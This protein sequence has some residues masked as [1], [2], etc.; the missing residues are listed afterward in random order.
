MDFD[1]NKLISDQNYQRSLLNTIEDKMIFKNILFDDP[2]FMSVVLVEEMQRC[3]GVMEVCYEGCTSSLS[4][5]VDFTKYRDKI[6]NIETDLNLQT[7]MCYDMVAA[8]ICT[9]ALAIDIGHS[10]PGYTSSLM[11]KKMETRGCDYG[12]AYDW[13]LN[14]LN[15]RL[16][17][18]PFFKC[19]NLGN[20]QIVVLFK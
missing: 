6:P 9:A 17:I 10:S 20:G 7:T 4:F 8:S 2:V 15:C 16:L 12:V 5:K 3:I 11:N 1:T 14:Y 13:L 18:C 19:T